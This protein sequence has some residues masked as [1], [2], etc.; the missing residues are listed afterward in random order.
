MTAAPNVVAA[1]CHFCSKFRPEWRVHRLAGGAQTICDYCLD[2]HN[3]ALEFLG[4]A[5]PQGCQE[6]G[7]SWEILRDRQPGVEV[8]LYVVPRDGIYQLLCGLCVRPYVSARAD[9][10]R[11]TAYGH[12]LNL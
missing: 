2:W 12:Q 9:L 5:T 8:R 3:H 4:G 7:A 6:C 11:G 10:Y 1:R